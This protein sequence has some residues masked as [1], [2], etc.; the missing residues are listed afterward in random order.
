[1]IH[2]SEKIRHVGLHID[3]GVSPAMP[4]GDGWHCTLPAI[5]LISLLPQSMN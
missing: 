3:K 5:A 4:H 2:T 1:M